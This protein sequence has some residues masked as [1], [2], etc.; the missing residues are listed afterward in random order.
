MKKCLKTDWNPFINN[1]HVKNV[2]TH[3]IYSIYIR[4][5]TKHNCFQLITRKIILHICF[6]LR[7]TV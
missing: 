6:Y 2:Q 3:V 4:F 7:P 5:L 1:E